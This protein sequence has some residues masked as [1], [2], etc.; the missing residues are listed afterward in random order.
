MKTEKFP[1]T[2]TESGVSAKIYLGNRTQN[3]T[4]YPGYVV[5]FSLL[6][7]R[8]QV[9]RTDLGDA[10][11]SARDACIK[12]ANGEQH[13]L[14][15]TNADR[16]MYLRAGESLA[17]LNIP[18]DVA[19]RDHAEA[20]A[21]LAGKV[22]LVEVCRDWIKRNAVELKRITARTALDELKQQS[23]ADGKSKDRLKRMETVLGRFATDISVEVHTVTPDIISRWLSGLPLAERTRRHYRD[24]LGF[25]CRWLVL[26][27]YLPRG[28]NWLEGVQNYSKKVGAIQIYSPAEITTLLR[29]AEQHF[30]GMVPFLVIGAFAGLRHAEIARLDWSEVELSEQAGESFIE[31]K[32][33]KAKTDVRRLVPIRDNLKAWLLRYRKESG[34]VCEFANT[35]EQLAKLAAGANTTPKHNAV[36]H[37]FISYRV[38]ECSDVPK[39]SDEAGNSPQIIRTNYLRRVKPAQATEWFGIMPS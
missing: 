16:M 20:L 37:S 2:V 27:G 9:W 5:T 33:S 22:G 34:L 25:F 10:K 21:I 35:S 28:T 19:C 17:G 15:L 13:V 14:T 24:M 1:L 4:K 3:G 38:A 39:V 36:R 26:R 8:K 7:K 23:Q 11:T 31:V 6:G 12:I 29:H 30:K 18:I 32:A